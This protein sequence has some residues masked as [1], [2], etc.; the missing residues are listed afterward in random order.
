MGCLPGELKGRFRK[1]NIMAEFDPIAN[2]SRF[3]PT[4]HL[5]GQAASTSSALQKLMSGRIVQSDKDI[6]AGQ[7]Q[8]GVNQANIDRAFIT[9]GALP[10]DTAGL[11]AALD[12]A[13]RDRMLTARSGAAKAGMPTVFGK[14]GT[15]GIGELPTADIRQG[16]FPLA[17]A[18]KVLADVQL[19]IDQ[20]NKRKGLRLPGGGPQ[21][22]LEGFEEERGQQEKFK[23]QNTPRARAASNAALDAARAKTIKEYFQTKNPDKDV[24][25][26][27]TKPGAANAGKVFIDVDGDEFEVNQRGR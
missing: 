2:I 4:K 21:V 3:S 1:D 23:Q 20:K 10:G 13:R 22:G 15:L 26:V 19:I 14:A 11:Q 8:T 16:P 6:A 24:S 27:Y 5:Q 17:A 25:D 9:G 12:A 7:R 18:N